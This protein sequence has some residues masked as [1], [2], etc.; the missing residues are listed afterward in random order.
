MA[1]DEQVVTDLS[2]SNHPL[3]KSL[4][5]VSEGGNDPAVPAANCSKHTPVDG[6]A[7]HGVFPPN[8]EPSAQ[9]GEPAQSVRQLEKQLHGETTR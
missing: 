8:L 7:R 4:A 5:D 9:R 1:E 3:N 2:T 6:H